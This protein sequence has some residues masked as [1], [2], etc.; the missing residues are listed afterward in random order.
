MRVGMFGLMFVCL[1]V[2][3]NVFIVG[4]VPT[5]L[6]RASVYDRVKVYVCVCV[7][8]NW[9]FKCVY[10]GVCVC[11][12]GCI[13]VCMC[14]CA[15]TLHAG[16][17]GFLCVCTPLCCLVSPVAVWLCKCGCAGPCMPVYICTC[18]CC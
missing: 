16:L 11:M 8:A 7:Y 3:N 10:V 2:L 1:A 4:C 15:D 6:M 13:C 17:H 9:S 18:L 5:F 12:Y 14:V